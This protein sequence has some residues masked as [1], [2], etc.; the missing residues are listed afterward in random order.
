MKPDVTINGVSMLGLGWLRET[1][2]F[3]TPQSQSNTITVPGR[4]T[5]ITEQHD[6]SAGKK[7]SYSIYR[8]A[9][10]RSLSAALFRY[11]FFHAG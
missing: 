11:D 5:A 9:G 2:D 3:P 7:F 4:D 1:V 6:Y 8:G 10:A